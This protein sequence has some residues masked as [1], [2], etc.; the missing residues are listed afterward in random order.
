MPT[1]LQKA[2]T[3]ILEMLDPVD[4]ERNTI[5]CIEAALDLIER[6]IIQ[7]ATFRDYI[8]YYLM[9]RTKDHFHSDC[10]DDGDVTPEDCLFFFK[11]HGFKIIE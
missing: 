3:K 1:D 4:Y 2:R 11:E 5:D 7:K 9:E 10:I 8:T 6:G